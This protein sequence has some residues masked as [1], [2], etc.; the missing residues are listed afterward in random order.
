MGMW[1][2]IPTI[3]SASAIGMALLNVVSWIPP[4][5]DLFSKTFPTIDVRWVN[6]AFIVVFILVMYWILHELYK[7]L[8]ESE[9]R[10]PTISVSADTINGK[11]YLRVTNNGEKGIFKAQIAL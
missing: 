1:R 3:Q 11:Y 6:L 10:K 5:Q 2:R 8:E 7:K 4:V 9:N